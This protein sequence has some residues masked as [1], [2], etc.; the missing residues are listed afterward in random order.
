MKTDELYKRLDEFK[1]KIKLRLV[2]LKEDERLFSKEMKTK[3]VGKL[4]IK[5]EWPEEDFLI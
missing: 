1:E 4:Q 3:M 2:T 5:Q